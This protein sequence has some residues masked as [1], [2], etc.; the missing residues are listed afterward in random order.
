MFGMTV[1]SLVEV[2]QAIKAWCVKEYN[3]T[4]CY[5]YYYGGDE[6]EWNRDS[7]YKW[8]LNFYS[9]ADCLIRYP[10]ETDV[11]VV[12]QTTVP[13]KWLGF[14]AAAIAAVL[15]WICYKKADF[16]SSKEYTPINRTGGEDEVE[17]L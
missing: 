7:S 5:E 9:E 11:T 3:G 12:A 6:W 15:L 8:C 13:S 14:V 16:S 2:N 17:L 1:L 4:D 10:T